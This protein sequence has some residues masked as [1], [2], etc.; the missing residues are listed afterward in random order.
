MGARGTIGCCRAGERLGIKI[1]Q[2]EFNFIEARLHYVKGGLKIIQLHL[3][4][5]EVSPC[6]LWGVL[7]NWPHQGEQCSRGVQYREARGQ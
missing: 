6:P 3:N 2:Q 5:V 7:R 4:N 1:I